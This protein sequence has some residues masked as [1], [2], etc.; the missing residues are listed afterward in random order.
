MSVVQEEAMSKP[1]EQVRSTE[2]KKGRI[3]IIM[4]HMHDDTSAW[5]GVSFC[6]ILWIVDER[7][8]IPGVSIFPLI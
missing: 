8:D 6:L 3:N 4:Y 1:N 2:K 5:V 7:H